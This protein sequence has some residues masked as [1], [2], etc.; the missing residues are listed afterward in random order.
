ME[1]RKNK[2]YGYVPDIV[3][4]EDYVFGGLNLPTEILQENGQWD[5][6]IP[7]D[8]IQRTE[9]YD[10]FGCTIFGT[11]NALEFLFK[12]LFGETKNWSERFV[13]IFSQTRPPGNSPKTII[14]AIRKQCGVID[15]DFLPIL[16]AETYEDYIQPDPLPVLLTWKGEEFL[17]NYK[18]NY[19][20]TFCSF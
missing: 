12:R 2:N 1:E 6:F 16:K 5:E 9:R 7:A 15:D 3:S 10:T 14:E 13:Y 20:W 11:L 19:E 18:I 8:E 17:Q 4:D